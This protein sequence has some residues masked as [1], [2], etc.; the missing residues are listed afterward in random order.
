MSGYA[1]ITTIPNLFEPGI[2]RHEIVEAGRPI[3]EYWPRDLPRGNNVR[4][5]LNGAE[6]LPEER[7]Q[8]LQPGDQLVAQVVPGEGVTLGAILVQLIIVAVVTGISYAIQALT[9]PSAPSRRRE[10]ERSPTYGFDGLVSTVAPGTPYKVIYGTMRDGGHIIGQY[11]RPSH[12]TEVTDGQA[13]VGELHTLLSFGYGPIAGISDIRIDKNP[14]TDFQGVTSE[15]RAGNLYQAPLEGFERV[16]LQAPKDVD[17]TKAVGRAVF[18]TSAEADGF[19]VVIR[20]RGGL[21]RV[22]NQGNLRKKTV[23]VRVEYREAGASEWRHFRDQDITASTRNQFDFFVES[24]PLSRAVYEIGLTRLSDDD[25]QATEQS[26]STVIGVTE[27]LDAKLTYPREALLAIRQLP[28]N[29]VSGATPQY[30]A[31]IKGRILRVYS[32]PSTYV[33]AWSDNPAW[34]LLD[35]LTDTTYGCGRYFKLERLV[36]EDFIS[37]AAKCDQLKAK[38][39]GGP[40]EKQFNCNLTVDASLSSFDVIK[41]VCTAGRAV[42][43]QQGARW[44][45]R[46]LD[47][48]S[49][50]QLFQ[51]SR[52]KRDSFEVS[53][54]RRSETANV[55]I[56]EFLSEDHDFEL[57]TL[58]VPDPTIPAGEG[59]VPQSVNV[60]GVTTPSRVGRIV[61]HMVLANRLE[62]RRVK[63][64]VGLE[65]IA[66]LAGDVF[67]VSHDVPQ[68]GFSGRV[69]SVDAGGARVEL[70]REVTIEAGKAYELTVI[71]KGDQIDVVR[72]LSQPGTYRV[73]DVAPTWSATLLPEEDYAFGE[74]AKSTKRFRCVS[75]TRGSQP[76][77]RTVEG[78]E[79]NADVYGDDLTVATPPS[80]SALPDPGK[81]PPQPTQ[82]D[83][84]ERV[85]LLQ[86]GGVRM[87]LDVF[88]TLPIAAAARAQVWW[89]EK[90]TPTW[91][92][93]GEP[94]GANR[95]TIAD[96]VQSPGT[97]YEIS[98]VSVSPSGN[99]RHPDQGLIREITTQ[100]VARRPGKVLGFTVGRSVTGIVFAW[101]PLDAAETP[102]LAYYEIRHG[103]TWETGVLVG[104]PTSPPFETGVFVRGSR[105]F[106]IK[107][108]NRS[109]IESFE[110]T[111]VVTTIEG[112]IGENIVVDHDEGP[113]FSGVKENF[114]V[115][116]SELTLDTDA[117]VVAWR[118]QPQPS[119]HSA[120]LPGGRGPGFKASG[121]Y[122]SGPI[123]ITSANA[124]RCLVSVDADPHVTDDDAYWTSPTVGE[125]TWEG[126]YGSS[127]SWAGIDSTDVKVLYE[128]RFSST[129]NVESAFG[130][131]QELSQQVEVLA[132]Y[133][134][135]RVTVEVR[136]PALTVSFDS[137]RV[138]FDVPDVYDTGSAQTSA[139]GTITVSFAKAFNNPPKVVATVLNATAGD[140]VVT[141]GI[142]NTQFTLSVRN[143]GALV[144][145]TVHWVAGG[146]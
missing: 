39:P 70:D 121:V 79:Y 71:H 145:R 135:L 136:N 43:V 54:P 141:T 107:A 90:G 68:W 75:I 24:P 63:L 53:L 62:R 99:R 77:R 17:L 42:F 52:I 61:R 2:R 33:E 64:D 138:L 131:W 139:V 57:D 35:Y 81:I 109:G 20:F 83:V 118:A 45:V 110:A 111:A 76:N 88:F 26:G 108:F 38:Y 116:S 30:N 146:Y 4:W 67:E 50:T 3:G 92:P 6:V 55:I 94:T 117:Q 126:P 91:E 46:F 34:I 21:F 18:S 15:V 13:Q 134:Q 72:V 103:A 49:P 84:V 98:V 137:I 122:V 59:Q 101:T 96:N 36:L 105:T 129:T 60:T 29:Q 48:E 114:Q 22:N 73:L 37:W 1:R 143:A 41:A 124:V 86:D 102:D 130:P 65:A 123:Q 58:P 28:T 8:T 89:R 5:S 132:K 12:N 25:T 7:V 82:M 97:T 51:M 14:Y 93:A 127:R 40:L 85:E 104:R 119:G 120:I 100:G 74:V 19:E 44:G 142:T 78:V 144:S 115:L 56:G 69:K 47:R 95:F 11:L 113:T 66:M 125:Q 31:L 133:A 112:R 16:A 10:Q 9:A 106:M 80:S 128:L 140:E 32:T 23:T 27:L 87:V